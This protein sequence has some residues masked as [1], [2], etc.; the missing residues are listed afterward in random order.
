MRMRLKRILSFL[1]VFAMFF[2]SE[3]IIT[4]ATNANNNS[5]F[6]LKNNDDNNGEDSA[7]FGDA[8]SYYVG[9]TFY[10]GRY[11]QS[12]AWMSDGSTD[13]TLEPIEWKVLSNDG[14]KALVISDKILDHKLF[15]NLDEATT[16]EN[17]NLKTWLNG[18]F[19]NKAFNADEKLAITSDGISLLT[20]YEIDSLFSDAIYKKTTTTEYA[21]TVEVLSYTLGEGY[22]D[23]WLRR[24]AGV[25][26]TTTPICKF[27]GSTAYTS[28][29]A[30]PQIGV[31]PVLYIDLASTYVSSNE[32]NIIW[33]VSGEAQW[34]NTNMSWSSMITYKEGQTTPLPNA[35]CLKKIYGKPFLGWSINGNG[36][37]TEIPSTTTGNI[38]LKPIFET[39]TSGSR[40]LTDRE[41]AAFIV[42]DEWTTWVRA[43]TAS[44]SELDKNATSRIYDNM[45]Y[46]DMQYRFTE[47]Y[48]KVPEYLDEDGKPT[49]KL[50]DLIKKK[51][52]EIMGAK[53]HDYLCF[54]SNEN[55]SKVKYVVNGALINLNM[56]YSTDGASFSP[57]TY[58][59]EITLNAG[60]SIYV[61]NK[62]PLL[63]TDVDQYVRFDI[64]GKVEVS[65]DISSLVNF[66]NIYE[67]AFFDLF[68]YSNGLV[69]AENLVL[70]YANVPKGAY[71]QM[72]NNCRNLET[73]P[74]IMA[75]ALNEYSCE[76]MFLSC[77]K[78]K[79]APELNFK[80]VKSSSCQEMF[81]GCIKL[82]EAPSILPA[83]SLSDACYYKMFYEC[84]SL[85]KAPYI[86]ATRLARDCFS[87][88]FEGCSS[89]NEIRIAYQSLP[90]SASVPAGAFDH[91]VSD[92]ADTGTFYCNMPM[93]PSDY[94]FGPSGL[95][96]D[97]TNKW[98]IM[99]EGLD[100]L[101]FTGDDDDPNN[102]V[103]YK[104]SN[105]SYLTL[106]NIYYQ[107]DG[108]SNW[109][110]WNEGFDNRITLAKGQ[111]VKIW[112]RDSTLSNPSSRFSFKMY[113]KIRA[114]GNVNSLRN[115]NDTLN[116][117]CYS[118][119]FYRCETL[120]T[121]PELPSTSLAEYCYESM[122]VG[123]SKL[124]RTPE[125]PATTLYSNCYD[126]M[127]KG[128]SSITEVPALPA[129]TMAPSCYTFMF[130][131]CSKI[132]SL[133][134]DL[135]AS[136]T[137]LAESCFYGMFLNCSNL[138]S[139]PD[140]PFT[141][142]ARSC[143]YYMFQDCSN[144]VTAQD[145]L[146]A[147]T[148]A[149]RCYQYM[150]KNCIKLEKS[151]RIC[152][153]TLA[154]KCCEEMFFGCS[155]LKEISIDYTGDDID[156]A[157]FSNWVHGVADEGVFIY[158]GSCSAYGSSAIPKNSTHKW[159]I[160]K[161]FTFTSLQAGSTI[162]YSLNGGLTKDKIYYKKNSDNWTLWSAD[163]PI[164]LNQNETLKVSNKDNT[165]SVSATQYVNFVM[166]G[167]IETSGNILS[168]I[169]DSE[170]TPYC[171]Y[172]L[173]Y[174]CASLANTPDLLPSTLKNACYQEM[175]SGCTGIT[176]A[177]LPATSL[178]NN[179]YS[180]IF[181]NCSSLNRI[182]LGYGGAINTTYFS[183]WVSGV[184]DS[185]EI[186]YLGSTNTFGPSALPKDNT[187]KWT[188]LFPLTF[189]AK[190]NN[191]LISYSVP[192]T[193][194]FNNIY[195][196]KSNGAW[197]KW[198]AGTTNGVTLNNNETLRIIN[199]NNTLG[200]YDSSSSTVV[201]LTFAS[202][203]NFE[204]SGDVT[205][206]INF[207]PLSD[208]CFS[209]LFSNCDKLLKAPKLSST[210]LAN[211]CYQDMFSGC[212]SLIDAP[213]LPSTTLAQNCYKGMFRGCTQLRKA[214]FLPA[215]TLVTGCY[216]EMFK[217]C[218]NL[219]YIKV[220]IVGVS[221]VGFTDKGSYLQDWVSGVKTSGDFYFTGF[222]IATSDFHSSAIPYDDTHR[223]TVWQIGDNLVLKSNQDG[224]TVKYQT[225]KE[226]AGEQGEATSDLHLDHI[227]Y[228]KNNGD[229]NSWAKEVTVN[230]NNGDIME[231]RNSDYELS[232]VG[233]GNHLI[234]MRFVMT[235]SIAA[236]GDVEALVNHSAS[237]PREAFSR[238][239][240]HCSALTSAPDLKA[241]SL[242][243]GCYRKMFY[244]CTGLTVAPRIKATTFE[245]Y[246]LEGMFEG[247][248]SLQEIK[249]DYTGA[250]GEDSF[251]DW[252][253]DVPSTGTFYYNGTST[254]RGI[255]HI[256]VGW[257]VQS[258]TP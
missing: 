199:R 4:F 167:T 218:S 192:T 113:K 255:D 245:W 215:S 179:C 229:W 156:G 209:S 139:V 110:K 51:R 124:V 151:P 183:N 44:L 125:L 83:T 114:S 84:T 79:K 28:Y 144:L 214:P 27:N 184:A 249:I 237:L 246:S 233:S 32:S 118:Y 196:Q 123:C 121:P 219:E 115:F 193:T 94:V 212:T 148:L 11:P 33:D 50:K 9:D 171:F 69:S 174:N 117:N 108:D 72:F 98:L 128:C 1:L 91:W 254:T 80:T 78:L 236:S 62:S 241:S 147:V 43:F 5:N 165:L 126:N 127:F 217:N 187:N 74:K 177:S 213:E 22:Q 58:N 175:F 210:T 67:Q 173:F 77:R 93:S 105:T 191:I 155:A 25:S 6:N 68:G 253:K 81:S 15:H 164:T 82:I 188:I 133:P 85:K 152:A 99:N 97:D 220:G 100:Y 170:L 169:N 221:G 132:T 226:T 251:N 12:V 225:W 21:A 7:L 104:I 42:R 106:D 238:L 159:S 136:V 141:T 206:M 46:Y 182:D 65:G 235:G 160:K 49:Q 244:D 111:K 30:T 31:R 48:K 145:T 56:G 34:L 243:R 35:S 89:L 140:L 90:T 250:F 178:A 208:Y 211:G 45:D 150:F 101:T 17:S 20:I 202:T 161:S 16:F 198:D 142:L 13:N 8:A 55:G 130:G 41:K 66:G 257:T 107:M 36:R 54:T 207:S 38:T 231:I 95:P 63:S 258:F 71:Q 180:N 76:M 195:Y 166:T 103:Y 18:T 158:D 23:Y 92:V 40:E 181:E 75:T 116:S 112:N 186:V 176:A 230:L 10:F 172:R 2:S 96:K 57:W 14:S 204:A 61:L 70:P 37:Y 88:M 234:Y 248:T 87:S 203:G 39:S 122:F 102:Y 189:T 143:Y 138:T 146:P 59:K 232:R 134:K 135:F 239:F 53:V 227:Q 60:E 26:D 149:E 3:S 154:S 223:W 24:E 252:V 256:P 86:A 109:T 119:L 247:C 163:T 64:T 168:L 240:E 129:S 194:S 228:R 19:Y 29:L 216:V 242:P 131:D 157:Y 222:L 52:K 200:Y 47:K 190:E 162:K 205:S 137:T 185:G 201:S 197:T 153:T 73:A 120:I 224:S